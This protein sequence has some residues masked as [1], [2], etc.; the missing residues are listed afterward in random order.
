MSEH[1]EDIPVISEYNLSTP[2]RVTTGATFI[3]K[4]GFISGEVEFVNYAKAKYDSDIADD[5][6]AENEGVKAEY[7]PVV[8][9]RVVP[10]TDMRFIEFAQGI[11][12]C[13]IHIDK[14]AMLT[15]ASNRLV[16]GLACG[17]KISLWI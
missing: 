7:Q 14:P 13:R 6:D 12:T 1:F 11:T 8:N 2:L 10:N 9:Y 4:F 17:Q 16:V 5:F 3:S 15:A